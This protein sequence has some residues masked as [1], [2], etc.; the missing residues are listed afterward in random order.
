MAEL[1]ER[2][3][4]HPSFG[5]ISIA[6]CTSSKNM[7]LFGSS[8]LHR[9]FIKIEVHRAF[10][11]R[12]VSR[13]WIMDEGLPIVR[14]YLSPSQFAD[15]ITSLNTHGTPCTISFVDGHEVPEPRLESK[16]IQFDAEFEEKMAEVA[17]D[18]NK[19][20]TEIGK[21]LSKP[22]IGKHDKEEIM[23]QLDQLKMQIESNIPFMKKSWTEQIDQTVV[24]VKNEITAFLEDKVKRMGLEQ[25]KKELQK[26]LE[27]VKEEKDKQ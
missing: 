13:D 27:Y 21:I 20:Y 19:F 23:K 1:E 24:E 25:Y 26:S 14:F 7:N 16:R 3:I 11:N 4:K 5:M 8:I 18:T 22:S 2:K 15:A 12:D 17:S 6:R 10:L 9:S